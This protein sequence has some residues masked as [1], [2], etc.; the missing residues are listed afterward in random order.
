MDATSPDQGPV[1][2]VLG[3]AGRGG[4]GDDPDDPEKI[5]KMMTKAGET[6]V[7][8][9]IPEDQ[10]IRQKDERQMIWSWPK[11]QWIYPVPKSKDLVAKAKELKERLEAKAS[12]KAKA[13]PK[14][15]AKQAG[16][17]IPRTPPGMKPSGKPPVPPVPPFMEPPL[18]AP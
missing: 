14:A 2:A 15:K 18:T 5:K 7:V 17:Q 3:D 11:Q 16:D 4:G 8:D 10:R 1:V 9:D 12:Q 13:K 6:T